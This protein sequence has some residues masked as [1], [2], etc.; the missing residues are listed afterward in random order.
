MN[1]YNVLSYLLAALIGA[2]ATLFIQ[3]LINLN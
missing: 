3:A 2:M 1:K